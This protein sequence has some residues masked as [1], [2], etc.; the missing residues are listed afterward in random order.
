MLI[1][2]GIVSAMSSRVA[3]PLLVIFVRVLPSLW[4]SHMVSNN[5]V[6]NA[7]MRIEEVKANL[8]APAQGSDFDVGGNIVLMYG[9]VL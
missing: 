3:N 9:A 6:Y 5:I 8:P 1:H 4:K 7:N 2:A